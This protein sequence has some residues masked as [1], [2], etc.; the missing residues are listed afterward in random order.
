MSAVIRATRGGLAGRRLQAVIIALVVLAGTATSV[1]ALGLL[2]NAHG[3][4]DRAFTIQ[5]GADVTA[6]MDTAVATP[7]R[8]AETAR[9]AD[10]TAAAGPFP[11]TSVTASV[12]VPGVP[13]SSSVPLRIVGRTSPDGAVDDLTLDDGHWPDGDGQVVMA[14]GDGVFTGSVLTIGGRKLTVTGVADSVTGTAD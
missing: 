11:E 6:I 1:V 12:T 14:R 13:G 3:P 5:H 2:A 10:V 9:L 7:P 4:F 8:L